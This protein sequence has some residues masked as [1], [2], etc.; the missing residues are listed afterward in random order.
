VRGT[1]ARVA[2]AI[3]GQ[4]AG[5][6]AVAMVNNA[7]GYPPYEGRINANPD[8]GI[9]Y[10]VTIP[11]LGVQGPP[12]SSDSAA[13]LAATSATFSATTIANPTFR[14]SPRSVRQDRAS[15]TDI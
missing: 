12:T 3:F 6:A 15:A 8:T 13:I 7:P 2:R 10:T 14:Q 11:F 5:A 4:Q 1:C 9:A